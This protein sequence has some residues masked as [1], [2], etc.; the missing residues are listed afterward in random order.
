MI[1]HKYKCI[2]IHQRKCAGVSIMS[3]FGLSPRDAAWHFMNDGVL[4]SEF[5]RA[6][7]DYLKFSV[8]RNP[9]ERFISGWRYC[10]TT[11]D[12][13]LLDVLSDLPTVGHDY[14][15]ITRPQHAIL[16]DAH[17]R[18]VVDYLIDF[19]SLQEGFNHVCDLI[20][21]PRQTLP[22]HNRGQQMGD[23]TQLFDDACRVLFVE[24]F[25][26]DFELLGFPSHGPRLK[27]GPTLAG[28]DSNKLVLI[29]DTW[30]TTN[31]IHPRGRACRNSADR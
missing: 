14:R 13:N 21:K 15:H 31:T 9:W 11:R 12:R 7:A 28:L 26:R 8:V 4:R 24:H 25:R 2:F 19:D 16:F 1:C 5:A 27:E 18:I 10:E 29:D 30:V 3:S 23:C 22:H 6:P 17:E 20:G